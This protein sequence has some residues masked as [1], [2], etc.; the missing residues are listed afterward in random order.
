[1]VEGGQV[2]WLHWDH[3]LRPVLATDA[4]G[5]VVWA[6]RYLPFG[7]I[8]QVSVDTGALTQTLRFPGQW[9]QAETGLHQNWMR[10]YDPTTGRYLEADPLGL[11]D[12]PSVYGYARQSPV[13]FTDPTGEFIPLLACLG[14]A[15]TGALAVNAGY[16]LGSLPHLVD[17]DTPASLQEKVCEFKEGLID[18][19]IAGAISGCIMVVTGGAGLPVILSTLVANFAAGAAHGAAQGIR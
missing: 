15:A 5:A 8:D 12:G 18:Q 1:V 11:V 9:F 17:D 19:M 3:I 2:F 4:T 7:G 14:G 10:D 16:Q 6:A 13:R